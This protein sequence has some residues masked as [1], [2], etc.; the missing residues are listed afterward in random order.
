MRVLAQIHKKFIANNFYKINFFA[1]LKLFPKKKARLSK[2][3]K[4]ERRKKKG[5]GLVRSIANGN[6]QK[7]CK[8][9]RAAKR[10]RL[11]ISS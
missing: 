2:G 9:Q 1:A 5:E 8:W 7:H 3:K 6:P 10:M 11:L 4:R